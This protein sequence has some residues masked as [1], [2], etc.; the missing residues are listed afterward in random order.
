[1]ARAKF[2]MTGRTARRVRVSKLRELSPSVL[3]KI[4]D[5]LIIHNDGPVAVLVAYQKFLRMQQRL[6]SATNT[7]ELLSKS[8]ELAGLLAGVKQMSA[9]QS[10]LLADID[11]ELEKK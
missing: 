10:R 5:T 1:M 7:L 6:T 9:G 3:K 2:P 4:E 8:K 11:A